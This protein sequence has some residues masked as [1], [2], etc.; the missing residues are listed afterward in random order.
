M[1]DATI[2]KAIN[3]FIVYVPNGEV[4]IAKDVDAI[5]DVLHRIFPTDPKTA[6]TMKPVIE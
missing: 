2:R 4:Y 6:P 1:T 5:A 3:G